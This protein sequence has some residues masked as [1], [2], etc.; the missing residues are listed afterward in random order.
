MEGQLLIGPGEV[1]DQSRRLRHDGEAAGSGRQD[2]FTRRA[3]ACSKVA[4][5][6]PF[7]MLCRSVTASVADASRPQI[8]LQ[9]LVGIDLA[10]L[11]ALRLMAQRQLDVRPV[12]GLACHQLIR[13][14]CLHR[15][16]GCRAVE[17]RARSGIFREER[18]AKAERDQRNVP[19]LLGKKRDRR[20]RRIH[21][22][23][24]APGVRRSDQVLVVDVDLIAP[25]AQ[26]VV[27]DICSARPARQHRASP[28]QMVTLLPIDLDE[29]SVVRRA[30]RDCRSCNGPDRRAAEPR[31]RNPFRPAA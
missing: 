31:A 19:G 28:E 12:E 23:P 25:P 6:D 16:D 8:E 21:S 3:S 15:V 7:G 2:V 20:L 27:A 30:R 18:L 5:S 26:V 29:W 24:L 10:V 13:A 22:H 4:C 1:A 9:S 17:G 11:G 14:R